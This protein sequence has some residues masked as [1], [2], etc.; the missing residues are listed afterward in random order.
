MTNTI[1]TTKATCTGGRAGTATLSDNPTKLTLILPKELG[2]EGAD[3]GLNPEQLFAITY[4]SCFEGACAF[5]YKRD[6]F[7][8]KPK[9]VSAEV[10]LLKREGGFSISVNI[11]A[12]YDNSVNHDQAIDLTNRAHIVCPY[13]YAT[14]N[15]VDVKLFNT[16]E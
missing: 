13:S 14:M 9:A 11:T 5:V 6:S 8:F 16:F 10:S 3:K 7:T 2:G 15:N 4:A 1:Y 12:H